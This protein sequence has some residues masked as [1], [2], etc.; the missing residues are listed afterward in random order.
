MKAA[1]TCARDPASE[2][3]LRLRD[4]E[5]QR[6]LPGAFLSTA[7]R[8]GLMPQLDPWVIRHGLTQVA[9]LLRGPAAG[10][11][12]SLNISGRSLGEADTLAT[13]REVLVEQALDPAAIAF[14]VQETAASLNLGAALHFMRELKALGCRLVLDDFG[15]GVSS[16]SYLKNLP[17]DL[18]K[19]DGSIVQDLLGS[20]VDEAIVRACNDVAHCLGIAT[21]AE[22]VES[23]AQLALLR[24]MGLNYAQGFVYDRPRPLADFAA[25]PEAPLLLQT[26]A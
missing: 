4:A 9:R 16:F 1:S 7:A 19:I 5:G 18:I 24:D 2:L 12:F 23:D 21:V 10:H 20:R 3:L 26:S 14:E 13:I 8:H 22:S 17:V 15:S 25:A 11:V 6:I